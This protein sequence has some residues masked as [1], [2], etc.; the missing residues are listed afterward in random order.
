MTAP[1][2]MGWAKPAV[3]KVK[4]ISPKNIAIMYNLR[5]DFSPFPNLYQDFVNADTF[6]IIFM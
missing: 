2:L 1:T 5:M 6:K 3:A 4:Q